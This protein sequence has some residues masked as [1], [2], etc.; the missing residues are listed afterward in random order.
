MAN[1]LLL[2][3]H[4]W[5]EMTVLRKRGLSHIRETT[6]DYAL[7]VANVSN[8]ALRNHF[9][10][11]LIKL[12][13]A[14]KGKLDAVRGMSL[15][16]IILDGHLLMYERSSTR[17]KLLSS[18][19]SLNERSA[20]DRSGE[21]PTR[22]EKELAQYHQTTMPRGCKKSKR[23]MANLQMMVANRR[24]PSCSLLETHSSLA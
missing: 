16:N 12:T 10:G 19:A 21:Y 8:T 23:E 20:S 13:E 2:F 22:N 1:P 5:I 6:N 24:S 3:I 18:S 15:E 9:V 4:N 17:H 11:E 14:V 7:A